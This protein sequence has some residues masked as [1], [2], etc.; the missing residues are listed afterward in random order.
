M[1]KIKKLVLKITI[2]NDKISYKMIYTLTINDSVDIRGAKTDGLHQLK[3][4][5]TMPGL[6][7]INVISSVFKAVVKFITADTLD[8][9]Y[10]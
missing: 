3:L 10:N 2:I 9:N 1:D 8:S 7:S 4:S 5:T 6:F